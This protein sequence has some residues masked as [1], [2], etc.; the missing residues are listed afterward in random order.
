MRT[1]DKRLIG[2]KREPQTNM[3]VP[4]F[5]YDEAMSQIH[6]TPPQWYRCQLVT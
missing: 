5:A 2:A 4:R 6:A 3:M 1:R